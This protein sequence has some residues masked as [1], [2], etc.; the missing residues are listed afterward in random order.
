MS[1]ISTTGG[2]EVPKRIKERYRDKVAMLAY[3]AAINTIS[4][5]IYEKKP[6]DSGKAIVGE[7][8]EK[9]MEMYPRLPELTTDEVDIAG[10]VLDQFNESGVT[11]NSELDGQA[12]KINVYQT[13]DMLKA[14]GP[15]TV[16]DLLTAFGKLDLGG[17]DA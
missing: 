14:S 7:E 5:E 16:S 4:P 6:T 12:L 9:M 3:I 2:R 1:N 11:E 8:V 10:R 13:E 17:K 15:Y